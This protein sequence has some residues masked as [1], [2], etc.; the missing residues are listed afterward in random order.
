[1]TRTTRGQRCL[2][3]V[4]VSAA[5]RGVVAHTRHQCKNHVRTPGV[6]LCGV[7]LTMRKRGRRV[8][9]VSVQVKDHQ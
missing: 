2:A 8:Y 9:L 4:K 3:Q 6:V 5:L 1:M 7:H